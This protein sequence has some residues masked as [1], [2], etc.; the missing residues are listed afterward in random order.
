MLLEVKMGRSMSLKVELRNQKKKF[1]LKT[2][3]NT[4]P[5]HIFIV[6]YFEMILDLHKSCKKKKSS[7]SAIYSS[8]S[9]PLEIMQIEFL[10]KLPCTNSGIHL[11]TLLTT[12][13]FA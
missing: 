8:P 6:F 13:M 10:F 3:Y 9:L 11:W 5:I 1:W 4:N 12:V 2:F 7:E